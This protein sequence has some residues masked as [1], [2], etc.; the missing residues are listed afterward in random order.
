ML[1]EEINTYNSTVSALENSKITGRLDRTFARYMAYYISNIIS[2]S[3]YIMK[4]TSNK[5]LKSYLENKNSEFSPKKTYF[6]NF[7][8][9]IK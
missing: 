1:A 6:A 7:T 5:D 3:E 8:D 4:N 9:A 2:L